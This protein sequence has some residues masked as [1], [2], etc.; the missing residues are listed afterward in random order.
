METTRPQSRKSLWVSG[1]WYLLAAL[2]VGLGILTGVLS[3]L[4]AMMLFADAPEWMLRLMAGIALV[5]SGYGMGRFAGFRRRRKGWRCGLF[6]GLFLWAVLTL[7]SLVWLHTAGQSGAAVVSLRRR[8]LGWDF[9]RQCTP[10]ET[11][12]I[13]GGFFCKM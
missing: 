2:P 4:A 7:A 8:C 9:R 5:F 1:G 3:I 10:S 12:Q 6:C 11:A 13:A